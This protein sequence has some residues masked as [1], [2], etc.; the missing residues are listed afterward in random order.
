MSGA[1]RLG[2]DSTGPYSLNEAVGDLFQNLLRPQRVRLI[3]HACA[4]QSAPV[5]ISVRAA[6]ARRQCSADLA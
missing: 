5:R 2:P 6:A 1:S 4:R 3:G